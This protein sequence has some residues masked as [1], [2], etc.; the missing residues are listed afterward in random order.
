MTTEQILGSPLDHFAPEPLPLTESYAQYLRDRVAHYERDI[1]KLDHSEA[2]ILD[3]L[4][5]CRAVRAA[6]KDTKERYTRDLGKHALP[7]VEQPI[8]PVHPEERGNTAEQCP[9]CGQPMYL[10][11]KYRYVH[12]ID[13]SGHLVWVAAGEWCA[14]ADSEPAS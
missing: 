12:E 10:T 3:D 13:E 1:A 8:W 11:A 5:A 2:N 6:L 4:A 14:Q 9:K 7:V